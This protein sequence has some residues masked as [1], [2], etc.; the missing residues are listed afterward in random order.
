MARDSDPQPAG[1]QNAAG[2]Q[3]PTQPDPESTTP[4]LQILPTFC[5]AVVPLL[6]YQ[7]G[8]IE[9]PTRFSWCCWS[10]QV[11]KS[12]T[13]S[14]RRLLRGLE[15]RRT[16]V[17]LSAGERQSAE[18]MVKVRQHCRALNI[19][20]TWRGD[21]FFA[22]TRFRQLTVELPNGVRIIGLPANPQTAR[23]FTG[24]V[25]LDEFA[26]HR[27]DREIWASVFPTVLRGGG[28][29][30]VASTPRGRDNLFAELR[31]NDQF[32]HSIVTLPDAIADG[33]EVDADQIRRSMN[34]DDLYRQEFLCEFLDETSRFLTYDQIAGVEDRALSKTFNVA[35][36][37]ECRGALS[38]GVDIGRCR[39][40]TVIWVVESSGATLITRGVRE[41]LGEP[42][43]QQYEILRSLF[44]LR[45]LSRCCIDAGGIGMAMAE[46]AL[47]EFGS[48]RVEAVTFTTAVKDELASRLRMRVEE[49]T[50]RIP[51]DEAIRNDWYSIRRSVAMAGPARYEASR[52]DGGHGDR[53]WAACLAVRAA[54]R[55]PGLIEHVSGPALQFRRQGIW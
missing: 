28:E 21:Q 33:L 44:S 41:S 30:D 26:M 43:R 27:D 47:E 53:F 39:D 2:D 49:T 9:S 25:F 8:D 36:L 46:A 3:P 22:G 48:S 15:R 18:L 5:P 32:T 13:K 34:D 52:A 4:S 29:L 19:A 24:D 12:F 6:P 42:F 17:F 50:I 51:A 54:G 23:G 35:A 7:R 16:Q 55:P 37:A 45:N 1:T 20:C 38:A 10:R 11:G 40:L 31:D 14:L